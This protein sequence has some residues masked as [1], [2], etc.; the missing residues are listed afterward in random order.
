MQKPFRAIPGSAI[1]RAVLFCLALLAA[2]PLLAAEARAATATPFKDCAECPEMIVVPAG[3]FM[4]GSPQTEGRL[5]ANEGPQRQVTIKRPFAVGMYAVT[6]DQWYAC[7]AD[8][9]CNSY[10]PD[11]KEWGRGKRPVINV[12]WDDAHRY[13]RWLNEKATGAKRPVATSDTPPP[14]MAP[15]QQ[16][17]Y[18]LLTEAEWEY[19][20][21]AGTTTA[22]YWGE[23]RGIG[24]A[25]CDGCGSEWDNKQTAPVGSFAPNPFGLYDMAGNVLQWVEDCYHDN[26]LKAPVDSTAWI[27]GDCL[28]RV[29]RGGSWYNSSYYL[30]AANRYSNAP[31]FRGANV[32]FRVAKTLE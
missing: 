3:K 31:Y 21:R 18:R 29:S 2:A 24:N 13:I 12:S 5:Y 15:G 26:Y 7:I 28:A 1:S 10:W 25:N 17:P 6:F 30:R 9:G 27:S 20:A 16:G 8:L 4:M 32:G 23:V 14:P 22:Y 19:A 11:D